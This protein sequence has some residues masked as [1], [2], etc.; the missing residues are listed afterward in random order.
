MRVCASVRVWDNLAC[1]STWAGVVLLFGEQWLEVREE[2]F[3]ADR[4]KSVGGKEMKRDMLYQTEE[5]RK[6]VVGR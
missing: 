6:L 3:L 2:Q 5:K 4:C 1:I